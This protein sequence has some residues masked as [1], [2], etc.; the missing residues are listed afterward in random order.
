M[1][2]Q[3]FLLQNERGEGEGHHREGLSHL[4]PPAGG[5]KGTVSRKLFCLFH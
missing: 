3:L 4:S 1:F 2:E 5:P